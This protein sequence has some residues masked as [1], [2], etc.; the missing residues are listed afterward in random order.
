MDRNARKT[1]A[2]PELVGRGSLT[3]RTLQTDVPT[4]ESEDNPDLFRIALNL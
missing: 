3:A 2:A 1:Y 4:Q